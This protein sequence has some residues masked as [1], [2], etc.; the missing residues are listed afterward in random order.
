MD[1]DASRR[2]LRYLHDV[3]DP[4]AANISYPS[5]SLLAITLTAVI[6]GEDDDQGVVE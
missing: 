3:P 6:C 5:S 4:C 1:I 2:P